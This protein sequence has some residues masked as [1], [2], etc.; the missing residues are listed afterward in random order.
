MSALQIGVIRYA[1]VA[2]AIGRAIGIGPAPDCRI[3]QGRLTITFRR[4]GATRWP[5]TR[6]LDHALQVASIA[7]RVLAADR[8]AAVR[9]R[10]RRAIVIVYE[11]AALAHGCAV[12]ARWECVVPAAAAVP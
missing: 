7:R 9:R 4:L 2:D 10:A 3:G 5:E 8:R 6:Q 11:D 12:T 1:S